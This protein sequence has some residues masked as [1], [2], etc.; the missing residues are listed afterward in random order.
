RARSGWRDRTH[1]AAPSSAA[2]TATARADPPVPTTSQRRPAPPSAANAARTPA[3]SVLSPT[4]TPSSV[5]NVLH[6]PARVQPSVFRVTDRST[7]SLCGTVTFPAPPVAAR[8]PR[9]VE[10]AAAGTR[11][12][13]YTALSPS[14]RYAALCI[15]G[16]RE[17]ATGSPMMARSRV[18][19]PISTLSLGGQALCRVPHE[20]LELDARVA[21]D[22]EIAAERVADLG[23]IP[24]APGVLA[25]H[26]DATLAAQLVHPGAVVAR[27]REDQ[28]GLLDELARQQA[29]AV[30]RE[31]ETALQAHEVGALGG[32]RPVPRARAGRCYLDSLDAAFLQRAQQQ[33]LGE[34]A[35]TDVAGADEQHALDLFDHGARRPA[36]RRSSPSVTAPSRTRRAPGCVQST[37]VEG[38]RLPSTPP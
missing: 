6:A 33:R 13:T 19:A 36:A 24:V 32:G 35:A 18:L 15:A 11:R 10:T 1:S 23:V 30:R 5:Q 8:A 37:P 17:C 20:R 34:R 22:L 7:A 2:A 25:E 4:S 14:A 3:T 27:H 9:T 29:G 38:G 12:A 31:I 26:E 21:V 28:V 16:E